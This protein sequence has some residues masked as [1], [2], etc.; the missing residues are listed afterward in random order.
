MD[1]ARELIDD[2]YNVQYY[3]IAYADV[4]FRIRSPSLDTLEN[5][6]TL[7]PPKLVENKSGRPKG[8]RKRKRN[9]IIGEHSTSP[10]YNERSS[11]PT[12]ATAGATVGPS[13]SQP[14]L[15][16]QMQA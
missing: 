7:L 11:A 4:S 8:K 13:L 1:I 16:Q 9:D 15:S 14:M 6:P 5:D 2:G 3:R 10:R 12:G